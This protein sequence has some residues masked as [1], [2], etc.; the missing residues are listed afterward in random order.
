MP[1]FLKDSHMG[2]DEAGTGDYF[3][4]ITVACV[5]ATSEQQELLRELGVR[6]S[7]TLTDDAIR[8]VMKDVLL[9]DI[10]TVPLFLIIRDIIN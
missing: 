1:T 2:S 10:T 6:D 7:K 4:P 5:F 9:T 3:G 8:S